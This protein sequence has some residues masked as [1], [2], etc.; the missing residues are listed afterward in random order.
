MNSDVS[1]N[2]SK[3]LINKI[4]CNDCFSI[5]PSI[6]DGSV[7]M[8]LC[9]LPY[10]VTARNKWD[11]ILPLDDLWKEYARVL[12]SNGV[13][14]LTSQGMFSAKLMVSATVKYQYSMV[15]CKS[16]VTNYLNAHKQPLR[17]HEDVL[18][19]YDKQPAYNPQ[20]LVPKGSVT[21]MGQTSTTN[22]GK[23]DRKPY[24]QEYSN[25]PTT[26][27][28]VKA[29][30]TKSHPTEKPVELFD[31]LIKTFTNEGMLVLDNCCGSGT[32][33]IAAEKNNRNFICIEKDP[34]YYDVAT[35]RLDGFRVDH[36][37]PTLFA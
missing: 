10:G 16:S 2:D 6:K 35:K 4:I 5:L 31:Y 3:H 28:N 30:T 25:Y 14:V 23:Q 11:S 37:K 20:G 22:Y 17:K 32:T 19:F 33:A 8:V 34:V 15:W 21:R 26:L 18:V 27:I 36:P 24:F 1:N 29:S 13:V 9:D 12:K 7:D